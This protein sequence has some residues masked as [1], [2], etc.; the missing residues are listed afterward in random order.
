M[1]NF[2]FT[3]EGIFQNWSRHFFKRMFLNF[4]TSCFVTYIGRFPTF[5]SNDTILATLSY[6]KRICKLITT[7]FSWRPTHSGTLNPK[8]DLFHYHTGHSTSITTQVSRI[9]LV[10]LA[11]YLYG[12]WGWYFVGCIYCFVT[13]LQGRVPCPRGRVDLS[14]KGTFL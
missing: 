13:Q 14:L 7:N 11:E 3:L 8:K 4:K 10:V 5:I 2:K 12:V 1:K 6:A 9:F